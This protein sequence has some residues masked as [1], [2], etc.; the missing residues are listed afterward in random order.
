VPAIVWLGGSPFGVGGGTL[1]LDGTDAADPQAPPF[2]ALAASG[3]A[4]GIDAW[5][6]AQGAHVAP[7]PA[8][9]SAR[10]ATPPPVDAVGQ[11]LAALGAGDP[12]LLPPAGTRPGGLARVT[13]DLRVDV[14]FSGAGVLF[15]GGSLDIHAAFDFTG[16]VIATGGVRVA[17]G[18]S[19]RLA[20]AAW[21]TGPLQVD[22]TASVRADHAAIDAVDHQLP[23]PRLPFVAGVKDL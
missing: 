10:S 9:G 5:L 17:T 12:A 23:L 7:G 13:G 2:A 4:D 1:E 19:L 8:T 20:G 22:G 18:A 14:P 16:L 6:A 3:S 11:R 15:V 21:S